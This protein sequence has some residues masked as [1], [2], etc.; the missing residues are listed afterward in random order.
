ML[1]NRKPI[2]YMVVVHTP[3][4]TDKINKYTIGLEA[5]KGCEYQYAVR[6]WREL[7]ANGDDASIFTDY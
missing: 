7:K 4:G 1:E 3:E 5:Y 2:A 6:F